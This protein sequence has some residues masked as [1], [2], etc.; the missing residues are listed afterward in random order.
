MWCNVIQCMVCTQWWCH[1]SKPHLVLFSRTGD[2]GSG[3]QADDVVV[4]EALY[5]DIVL[6]KPWEWLAIILHLSLSRPGVKPAKDRVNRVFDFWI[7]D[8][9]SSNELAWL[10]TLLTAQQMRAFKERL[11]FERSRS[12][13]DYVSVRS[14]FALLLMWTIGQVVYISVC[15]LLSR[16]RNNTAYLFIVCLFLHLF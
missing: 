9:K 14:H 3:H 1:C 16:C 13:M 11:L 7:I 5:W 8:V 4:S 10:L 6:Q 12:E 15:G 2:S